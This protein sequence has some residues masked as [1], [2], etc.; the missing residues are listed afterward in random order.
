MIKVSIV[1]DVSGIAEGLRFLINASAGY[2]CIS[3]F[4]N[5]EEALSHLP[6]NWPDVIV[7]G[8]GLP[9]MSG[10]ECAAR[11]K[12]LRPSVNIIIFTVND[13]TQSI[14][15]SLQ[16]GASGYLVKDTPPAKIIEAIDDA[17]RGG[18]P[19]SSHIARKVVQFL[20]NQP[21][22]DFL[23]EAAA[24]LS[25]REIEVVNGL[26]KGWR[27]KEIASSLSIS[28]HTVRSHIRRIY[29]K[30]HVNSRTEATLKLSKNLSMDSAHHW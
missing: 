25:G 18:S 17:H 29:E 20:Q 8:I 15:Q 23:E 7:M 14:C 21:M 10:I 30:L 2:Q 5:A 28:V 24:E 4:P 6:R 19:M 16:A 22:N 9:K 1:E 26:A 11:I 13:D 12:A 27:Y 3:T